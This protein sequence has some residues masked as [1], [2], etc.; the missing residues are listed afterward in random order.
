MAYFHVSFENE[1]VDPSI[2]IDWIDQHTMRRM[3]FKR[4]GWILK[5]DQ[6]EE[7]EEVERNDE[8]RHGNPQTSDP[9]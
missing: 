2:S 9:R 3:G 4:G 1:E 8:E 6:E 5:G 7:D